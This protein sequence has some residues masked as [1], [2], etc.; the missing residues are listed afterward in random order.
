MINVVKGK[1]CTLREKVLK[2]YN[3]YQ[4]TTGPSFQTFYMALNDYAMHKY[5]LGRL[6]YGEFDI[7]ILCKNK[8]KQFLKDLKHSRFC[9]YYYYLINNYPGYENYFI[10]NCDCNN[11]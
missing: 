1:G 9:F 3:K 6:L 5:F 10:K 4:P 11:K 8:N 7:N 2:V